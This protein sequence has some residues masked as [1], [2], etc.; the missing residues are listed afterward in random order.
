VFEFESESNRTAPPRTVAL[1]PL[2]NDPPMPLF[3][4][5]AHYLPAPTGLRPLPADRLFIL[6]NPILGGTSLAHVMLRC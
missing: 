4:A 2:I 3:H 1:G 5:V 6:V